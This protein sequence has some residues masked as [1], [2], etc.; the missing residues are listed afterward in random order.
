[1]KVPWVFGFN[2]TLVFILIICLLPISVVKAAP[3]DLFF[4]EYIE[5]S[6]YNKAL[7][8]YN[9]TGAAV[10]LETGVYSVQ[11]YTNGASVPSQTVNLIGSIANGD[12]FVLSRLD[13]DPAITAQTDQLNSSVVNF[14]GNDAISLSKNGVI[15]DVIGQIGLDPGASWS[16]AGVSTVEM[17]LVRKDTICQGD[18]D[19]S[20]A[21]DPSLEWNG[22]PQNTFTYLGS[23]SINCSAADTAPTVSATVPANGAD[24]FPNGNDL[25]VTFSEPVDVTGSWFTLICTVSGTVTAVV[26]GGPTTY[27]INP[28]IDL[29]DGES[30]SLTVL[31]AQVGDQ[32]ILDPPNAMVS[33]HQISYTTV[34]YCAM[35]TSPIYSIQGNSSSAAIT[36]SVTTQ[37]IV[38]GD[39]EGASPA[40][41]G[42]Y[43]QDATGDDDPATSDGI[44]VYNASNN[45]VSV[46]DL[47]VVSGSADEYQ[48]QTQIG[49]V[50]LIA[51]CGTGS[52]SPTD[53][54]LPLANAARLNL[55]KACLCAFRR[56]CM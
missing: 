26:S 49:S 4:S 20:N 32:D 5:G 3:T 8:I 9:G 16:S 51:K 35:T 11:L 29:A 54:N 13:A 24:D 2:I 36:G 28:D 55:T 19:G 7:E 46:G 34:D 12:V 47:I 30:C 25:K 53:V 37:G 42:F 50:T 41:R 39:E 15:I 43:L 6:S 1:M 56:P 27:T 33:N 17:T 48:D 31:A 23:H 18:A 38:V 22:S 45:D 44:F 40:L 52:V 14:N 10:N 21:Y